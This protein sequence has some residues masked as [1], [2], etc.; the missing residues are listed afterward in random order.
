MCITRQPLLTCLSPQSL[1]AVSKQI[2]SAGFL[3][4]LSTRPKA[5]R[6]LASTC[7][8]A[9][10][11]FPCCCTSLINALLCAASV[12]PPLY[13]P[14]PKSPHACRRKSKQV[15]ASLL[16]LGMEGLEER[17]SSATQNPASPAYRLSRMITEV[18]QMQVGVS[19]SGSGESGERG[20][21][22]PILGCG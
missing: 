14:L 7:S 2:N 6:M 4:Q 16:E 13:L 3:A 12:P 11:V 5:K 17:L 19:V 22:P 21:A 20:A 8:D 18:T 10:A 9:H 15:E 1:A